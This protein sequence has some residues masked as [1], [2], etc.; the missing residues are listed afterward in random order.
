MRALIRD[1]RPAVLPGTTRMAPMRRTALPLS[2][3]HEFPG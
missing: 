2:P 1:A 3:L